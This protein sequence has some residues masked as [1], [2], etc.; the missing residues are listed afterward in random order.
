MK[1]FRYLGAILLILA[2]LS[3]IGDI[4]ESRQETL[5]AEPVAQTGLDGMRIPLGSSRYEVRV[6][7]VVETNQ[8]CFEVFPPT[9][10]PQFRLAGACVPSM[11][12]DRGAINVYP[13]P[14]GTDGFHEEYIVVV[15]RALDNET[16]H[17]LVPIAGNTEVI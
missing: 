7:Q 1:L 10:Q 9:D 14:S 15:D 8:E 12:R 17:I 13:N 16:I 5:A 6:R 3:Y 4:S 2:T 11:S